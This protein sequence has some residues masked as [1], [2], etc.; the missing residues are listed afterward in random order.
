LL[1]TAQILMNRMICCLP[2]VHIRTHAANMAEQARALV[3]EAEHLR[4]CWQKVTK[5]V[6]EFRSQAL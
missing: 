4:A 3:C 1:D 6:D 2:H 5:A